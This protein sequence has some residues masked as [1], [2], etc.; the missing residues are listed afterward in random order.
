M[1]GCVP[2]LFFGLLSL[3]THMMYSWKQKDMLGLPKK[4]KDVS[5]LH[6]SK[7]FHTASGLHQ[8]WGGEVVFVKVTSRNMRKAR[9][10]KRG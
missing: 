10:E 1:I 9:G 5:N 2:C 8:S 4:M 7:F 3:A 6:T